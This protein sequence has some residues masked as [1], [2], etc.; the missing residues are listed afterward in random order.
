MRTLRTFRCAFWC[1]LIMAACDG[2]TISPSQTQAEAGAAQQVTAEPQKNELAVSNSGGWP[3]EFYD[4]DDSALTPEEIVGMWSI[5]PNCAQ[6]TV[7]MADGM[8][9]DQTGYTGRW[10]LSNQRL[11]LEGRPGTT[12]EV[13]QFDANTFAVGP[14]SSAV[15]QGALRTFVIYRRC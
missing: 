9:T 15:P 7:F 12:N 10:T 5:A 8:Y 6:P 3:S 13:N 2:Q 11:S 14:P 1:P 4:T